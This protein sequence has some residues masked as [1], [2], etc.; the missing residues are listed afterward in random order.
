MSPPKRKYD[1]RRYSLHLGVPEHPHDRVTRETAER[2]RITKALATAEALVRA[3][4]ERENAVKALRYDELDREYLRSLK[5]ADREVVAEITYAADLRPHIIAGVSPG[6]GTGRRYGTTP[7]VR[8]R[9][10]IARRL[11][12]AG[13][14]TAHIA[15]L[16]RMDHSTVRLMLKRTDPNGR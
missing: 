6:T 11:K 15:R 3:E 7:V 14:T 8:A 16:L 1:W 12:D 10:Q 4:I 9:D 2:L 5:P 13:R